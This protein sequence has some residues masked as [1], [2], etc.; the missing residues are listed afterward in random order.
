MPFPLPWW[1]APSQ[2]AGSNPPPTPGA[3]SGTFDFTDPL[4]AAYAMM[5]AG[6]GTG[7]G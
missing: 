5:P 1:L 7:V 4:N 2:T 6:I 3:V